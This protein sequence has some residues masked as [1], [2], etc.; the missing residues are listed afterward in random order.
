MSAAWTVAVPEAT[1]EARAWW[2]ASRAAS[3]RRPGGC[4]G[5]GCR[6]QSREVGDPALD[7]IGEAGAIDGGGDGQDVLGAAGPGDGGGAAGH[8]DHGG[9]VALDFAPAGAGKEG[10]PGLG[11]VEVVVGGVEL[12]GDGGGGEGGE[13]VADKVGVDVALRVE[14]GLE[15]EDDEHLRDALLD[16]AEAASLPGP[17][18]RGDEPDDG[19]AEAFQV[20]GEAEVDVGEVDED[21]DGGPRALDVA[22]EQGI[23]G[24]DGGGVAEDFGDAH[25]GDVFGAHDALL[26]GG[27]HAEA[28]EAGESGVGE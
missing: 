14:A 11:G 2:S 12:A 19:D 1:T 7:E 6:G 18:L 5:A 26:A 23:A 22:D 27:L 13:G 10:D 16:P 28:A 15:G 4:R 9:E 8:F 20:F 17:E 25:V 24:V 21:G 3:G